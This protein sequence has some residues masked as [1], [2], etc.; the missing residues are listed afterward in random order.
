MNLPARLHRSVRLCPSL[1]LL[2]SLHVHADTLHHIG[3]G[4]HQHHDSSWVFPESIG[5]FIRIGTPQ[6]VD[7]T[8][9]VVA[10]YSRTTP[11][12]TTTAIVDVYPPTSAAP[13]TRFDDALRALRDEA[14]LDASILRDGTL[15]LK[16]KLALTAKK[17][18]TRTDVKAPR[19]LYFV[20]TGPWIVKI[21]TAIESPD[22]ASIKATD[23]F[24]R[25][26]QWDTLAITAADCTGS[27][28]S[29]S[30]R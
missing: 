15:P 10:Y 25:D 5:E 1:L 19:A 28:C 24:V 12:G 22:E 8:I 14:G 3:G 29:G 11:A 13:H 30:K 4:A 20:D 17:T 16:S 26:Q 21:R 9:D 27:A 6:D 23:D 7:G 18:A 2:A